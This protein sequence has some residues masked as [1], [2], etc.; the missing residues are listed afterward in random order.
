MASV[1]NRHKNASFGK[2]PLSEI[3]RPPIHARGFGSQITNVLRCL[4]L[5]ANG[6]QMTV[7][8]T[9]LVGWEYSMKNELIIAQHKG[10]PKKSAHA[11]SSRFWL[12]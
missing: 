6:Y 7:T 8:V 2:T 1:L 4:Q 9:K 3:W 5:E 12:N 10:V 11:V